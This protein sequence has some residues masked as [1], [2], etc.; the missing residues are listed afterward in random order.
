MNVLDSFLWIQVV[1]V[2]FFNRGFGQDCPFVSLVC[3]VVWQ[4]VLLFPITQ[5]WEGL[6]SGCLSLGFLS[7]LGLWHGWVLRRSP[8]RSWWMGSVQPFPLTGQVYKLE[9]SF[10]LGETQFH[11]APG[12][13][14]AV[15]CLAFPT[16]WVLAPC[17]APPPRQRIIFTL[18][19]CPP[20]L[21]RGSAIGLSAVLEY[22]DPS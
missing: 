4:W 2:T 18:C 21:S 11:L 5:L 6:S 15:Q 8:V 16:G 14:W 17:S 22:E 10:S 9:M 12:F 7:G 1:V 19:I 13:S 20:V 3:W